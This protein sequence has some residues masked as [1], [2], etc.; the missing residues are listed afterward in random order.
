MKCEA[1]QFLGGTAIERREV[2]IHVEGRTEPF[3]CTHYHML[4]WPDHGA[5]RE[6][7]TVRDIIR[8][9]RDVRITVDA[10]DCDMSLFLGVIIINSAEKS[11][12]III[13]GSV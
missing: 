6:T 8:A 13:A 3:K 12:G 9:V 1:N 2:S 7:G 11:L 4:C 10:C 5:P